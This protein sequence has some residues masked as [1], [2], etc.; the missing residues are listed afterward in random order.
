MSILGLVLLNVLGLARIVVVAIHI[1]T[2]G[3]NV[4]DLLDDFALV[5]GLVGVATLFFDPG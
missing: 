5:V 2:R 1:L 4:A 3:P